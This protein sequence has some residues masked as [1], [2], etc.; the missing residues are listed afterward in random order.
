MKNDYSLPGNILDHFDVAGLMDKMAK[1]DW[2]YDYS[3]DGFVWEKGRAEIK[4]ISEDLERL[5][6]LENGLPAANYLWDAYVPPY[7][8]PRPPFL[9][10][11]ANKNSL[12]QK[13]KVMLENN[14]EY[15]S[16][17]L[18]LTGFGEDL[19]EQLKEKM[20]QGQADFMLTHKKDY[21][22][23]S[24]VATL[25][26]R[27]S[28]ETDLYFFN[29]YNLMLQNKLHPDAIK[30]TFYINPKE[31]NITL[32]EAYNL[33]SGRAVHKELS[34]KEGEKYNAWLQLDFKET[35]KHGNFLTKQFHQKYGYDLQATLAKHPIK[36]L[37]SDESRQ[38]LTESLERGNRQSVTLEINGSERKI[39]IEAA[40]Q[41]KSLNFY[42]ISGQRIRT[43]KLYE[44]NSQ[45]Q[46]E[47][48]SKKQSLKQGGGD[49]D[50]EL[51]M[52]AKKTKRKGQSI[53]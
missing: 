12:P 6:K 18:L 20:Q 9:Q 29:R 7:S 42:E 24:T 32:K 52:D 34:N 41:F 15:L 27:K 38:R 1:A 39:F 47:K 30:Q 5:C 53:S 44:N 4:G 19:K 8:V 46:T 16:K 40:P 26:F 51:E 49:E 11:E 25:Q 2:Y 33:M 3:D 43:D 35:D 17:Q 31:D 14:Y 22:T 13:N 10:A 48:Q 28:D 37:A 21:G 23:D 36:E 50:G 45:E